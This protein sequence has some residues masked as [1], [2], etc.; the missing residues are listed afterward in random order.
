VVEMANFISGPYAAM[1]LADLGAEVVKVELP[2][3]GDPFRSWGERDDAIR[4]QFAAYNRGKKSV[5]INVE[6]DSGKDVYE[7]LTRTA[8]VVIE[9]FRPGTADRLG[10]GYE[11][12]RRNNARLIYCSISGMGSSG[13]SRDRPTYDAIAQATSGLWSVLTDLRN[14]QPVGPPMSDQLTGMFAAYGVLAALVS[15]A[16]TSTGQRIETSMLS[17]S[18]AFMTGP[19]AH[20]LLAGEIGDQHSRARRS[21]SYAFVASD[22]LPLA[23][24]LSSP[25]KF[26]IALTEAVG[27][28]ELRDDS[29]FRTKAERIRNYEDLRVVLSEVIRQRSREEWLAILHKHD[30]P[31]GPI[32]DIAEV[33]ADPQTTHLGMIQKFGEG[34]RTMDLVGFPVV[35]ENARP[36]TMLPPP[37]L[38]EHTIEV[39]LALGYAQPELLRLTSEG[40][41]S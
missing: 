32:F 34:K 41:I 4:P 3:T 20:Y 11:I 17:S 25:Q 39:L 14:P 27:H 28:P 26:W 12:L 22:R 8:D 5:T 35:F 40:A 21:Q 19:I 13:P 18:I 1:L 7:R 10:I 30:V 23:I 29:R 31:A 6:V 9:N 36:Q 38:G 16:A 15:R 2:G 33:L 24:H 37:Q